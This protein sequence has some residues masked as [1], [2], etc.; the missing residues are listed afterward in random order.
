MTAIPP[1]PGGEPIQ[2]GVPSPAQTSPAATGAGGLTGGGGAGGAFA[3]GGELVVPQGYP[4][5]PAP[6]GAGNAG[7]GPLTRGAGS[8]P[9]APA[10]L[11]LAA[12]AKP[13]EARLIEAAR[14]KIIIAPILRGE[15]KGRAAIEVHAKAH[16]TTAATLYRWVKAFR[17]GGDV[18]LADRDRSDKGQAR[19]II[20]DAWEAFAKAALVPKERMLE[21]AAEVTRVVR[22]LW[23]Q[24][25]K[26]SWR[27]V[28]LL[29]E[30][31]LI[32]LTA[33]AC[34]CAE[35]AAKA[36]C[37]LPRRFVEG[38]RRFSVVAL[39]DRDAKGFYDRTP[40]I[41]RD[42]STLKPGDCVFGDVSPADIPVLRPDGEVAYAR[43]IAWMDAATGM[44]HVT[45]H[46]PGARAAVRRE[47]VALSFTAMCQSA[48][49][50]MPKRLYLDNGSEYSWQQMLDAWMELTRLTKGAFGGTWDQF[51]AGEHYGIVTRSVPF[52]P[53]AK[54]IE[55]AFG[56]FLNVMG[57]HP[58]FVG[59][60]RMRKKVASL[61]RGVQ[62]VPVEDLRDFLAKAVAAYN[63]TPQSGHLGGKSP[64]ERMAEFLADGFTP[65]H[66]EAEALAFAF[67]ETHEAKVRM[68]QVRV[69]GWT[70]Y[71]PH[72]VA[73]DGEKIE[74]RWARHAPDA[75][76]VFHRSRL[77]AV[78]M[79]MPVFAWGDPE[80]AKFA[81]KL[82]SEARQVVEVMR[83]QVA[84]L[85]PRDLMG[86]FARLS[87]VAE[88]V[89]EA[90]RR[91]LR[92]EL[93]PEAQ[94]I[95]DARKAQM[96]AWLA[97]AAPRNPDLV[98]NRHGVV[99]E[100]ADAVRQW[101]EA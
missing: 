69:G 64:S 5:A 13:D 94:A 34:G 58:A 56:N 44:L 10:T 55:G 93:S 29:A 11:S 80:G 68:G 21:I 19:V 63:A 76:Y 99:D 100:E 25:G 52:K 83:G 84:W 26:P 41:R 18:A 46:L 78:A 30:P 59:S 47:H 77:V 75:A 8:I 45:G 43:M 81:A 87:G 4:L 14:R 98:A 92:I 17:H 86:E 96:E 71:H 40:A 3:G 20:S 85:D 101:L 1:A 65:Y 74:A 22:G 2:A 91:A 12:P 15:I 38:E 49:F 66:V 95:A 35:R 42:R 7:N 53:R 23:A 60:D 79:P 54:L 37:R 36:A 16:G 51:M 82:A 90:S 27:Q 24:Q 62:P 48:P 72:L 9:A 73:F 28:A 50:G 67:G 33:E 31:V 97:Q 88:V 32:R 61:G 39:K 6:T 57:W 70:Y 89:E